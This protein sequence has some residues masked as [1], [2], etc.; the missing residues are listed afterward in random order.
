MQGLTYCQAK[1]KN[2]ITE[3]QN[4][5]NVMTISLEEAVEQ[6]SVTE[7]KIKENNKAK[8]SERKVL[9]HKCT[10]RELR[11]PIKHDNIHSTGVPEEEK[12]EKGQ[13]IYLSKL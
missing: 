11:D 1:I 3:M 9:E 2:A 8:K 7:N 4:Q 5:L 10:L 13:K 12:K 6:I